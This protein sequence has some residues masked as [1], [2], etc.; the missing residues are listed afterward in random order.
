MQTFGLPRHVTQGTALAS[1][2]CAKERSD[3]AQRRDILKRWHRA[4]DNGLSPATAADAVGVSRA[5]LY[6]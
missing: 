1:R 3:E 4:R 2:L 5:I 6:R